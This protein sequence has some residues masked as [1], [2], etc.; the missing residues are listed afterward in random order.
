MFADFCRV[1]GQSGVRLENKVKQHI[2][3]NREKVLT[4]SLKCKKNISSN[5]ENVKDSYFIWND[6]MYENWYTKNQ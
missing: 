4:D 5:D 2:Y 6:D 1:V 3:D